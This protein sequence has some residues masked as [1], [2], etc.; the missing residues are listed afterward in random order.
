[1]LLGLTSLRENSDLAGKAS[2]LP[3]DQKVC[4]LEIHFFL[5]QLHYQYVR[6]LLIKEMPNSEADSEQLTTFF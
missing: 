2:H 5:Q 6:Y 1:M 4:W 3:V